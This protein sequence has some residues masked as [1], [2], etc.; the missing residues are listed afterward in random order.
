[1]LYRVTYSGSGRYPV[2]T[3]AGWVYAVA[4]ATETLWLSDAVAADL[5][6]SGLSVEAA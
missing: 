2:L 4:G 6:A 5:I 1:M 3:E